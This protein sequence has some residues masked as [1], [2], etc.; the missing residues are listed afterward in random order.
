[1]N[2]PKVNVIIFHRDDFDGIL[3]NEITRLYLK[4]FSK[5]ETISIPY[6]YGEPTPDLSE[7]NIAKLYIVDLAIHDL[8]THP[9]LVWIDHHISNIERYKDVQIFGLRIDQ[10]AACRLC[11]QYFFEEPLAS[12]GLHDSHR[13]GYLQLGETTFSYSNFFNRTL[14][15]PYLVTLIGEYDVWDKRDPN[16]ELLN[17]SLMSQELSPDLFNLLLSRTENSRWKMKELLEDGRIIRAYNSNVNRNL[18]QKTAKYVTLAGEIFLS[19]NSQTFNS[20]IFDSFNPDERAIGFL[21]YAW[22]GDYWRCSMYYNPNC[23]RDIDLSRIAQ[24]YQGGG[25]KKAAG[26][27]IKDFNSLPFN[28]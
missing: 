17:L 13:Q 5:L 21:C 8:M 11:W 1:M 27:I 19:C 28:P 25:H 4:E 23:K 6:S 7:F 9:K 26:F 3:S 16:A 18:T 2:N 10:V 12:I 22:Q 14:S 24:L 15:E 20:S